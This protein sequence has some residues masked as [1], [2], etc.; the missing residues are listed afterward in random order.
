MEEKWRGGQTRRSRKPK[1]VKLYWEMMRLEPHHLERGEEVEM[2]MQTF[3]SRTPTKSYWL[4]SQNG[5]WIGE[6]KKNMIVNL[7]FLTILKS[8]MWPFQ[9][10]RRE[11]K[12]VISCH[13]K[14][15][16]WDS[17]AILGCYELR[18][19]V[20]A[21]C[22]PLTRPWC[23]ALIIWHSWF[24]LGEFSHITFDLDTEV[25]GTSM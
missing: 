18:S 21:S 22:C 8:L 17:H 19:P 15:S 1:L 12:Y 25:E 14:V 24:S 5:I 9:N 16:F 3:T 10:F 13:Q 7:L 20:V 4:L 2:D 23:V 6:K 11:R